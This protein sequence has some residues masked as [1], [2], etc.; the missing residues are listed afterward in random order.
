M[1]G[2]AGVSRGSLLTLTHP[3]LG[4][5]CLEGK[6][7]NSLSFVL[8]KEMGRGWGLWGQCPRANIALHPRFRVF[9][10]SALGCRGQCA[11]SHLGSFAQALIFQ[12]P[13]DGLQG[14]PAGLGVIGVEPLSLMTQELS[15]ISIAFASRSGEEV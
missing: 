9:L 12:E 4:R 6:L 15:G 11:Y 7:G 2:V 5:L 14:S 8:P 10:A 13:Q 3:G 1:E